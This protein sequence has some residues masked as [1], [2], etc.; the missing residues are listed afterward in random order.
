MTH[1]HIMIYFVFICIVLCFAA[2]HAL[3]ILRARKT[4]GKWPTV[5]TDAFVFPLFSI[6]VCSSRAISGLD[7]RNAN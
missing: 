3:Q 5:E 1:Y 6:L 7:R 4:W 2:L